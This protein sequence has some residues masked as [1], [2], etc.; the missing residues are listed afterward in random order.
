MVTI[1]G[2][3][4]HK[5]GYLSGGSISSSSSPNGEE[6]SR[7]QLSEYDALNMQKDELT[8]ELYQVQSELNNLKD[9]NSLVLKLYE[10]EKY[11]QS[12]RAEIVSKH[13]GVIFRK[14]YQM[15]RSP[16]KKMWK[17]FLPQLKKQKG[18]SPTLKGLWTSLDWMQ[19]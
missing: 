16:Y 17:V 12:C 5:N 14:T 19:E 8:A 3:V 7:W 2:S 1:D 10:I 4:I 9:K 6:N 18:C 11:A 15:K 13:K